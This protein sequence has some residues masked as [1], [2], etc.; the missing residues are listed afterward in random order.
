MSRTAP[1]SASEH[2]KP[3]ASWRTVEVYAMEEEKLMA[4]KD[5]LDPSFMH[6][7]S[8]LAKN[9]RL[10]GRVEGTSAHLLPR[11]H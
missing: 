10:D 6:S 11:E 7:S 4:E 5:S 3:C 1:R 9:G 2:A 8:L